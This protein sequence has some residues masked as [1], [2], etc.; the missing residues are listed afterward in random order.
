MGWI[1]TWRPSEATAAAATP[2]YGLEKLAPTSPASV[3]SAVG[4]V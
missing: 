1:E 4:L 3:V 2:I